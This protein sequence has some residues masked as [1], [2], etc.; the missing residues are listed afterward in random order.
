M[1]VFKFLIYAAVVVAGFD[2]CEVD[3]D[4]SIRLLQEYLRINTTTYSDMQPAVDFWTNLA[5]SVNLPVKV[6]EFYPGMPIVIIKWEGTDD[7]LPRIMLN[8]HMDVVPAD[9]SLWT[10]NP[11][12]G[13]ISEDGKIYGVGSQDMKSVAIQHFEALYRLTQIRK[14]KLRRSIYMTLMSDE[15]VGG[16]FCMQPLVKSDYFKEMNIECEMDEG[17][18]FPIAPI[19]IFYQDKTPWHVQIDCYGEGGHGSTFPLSSVTAVGQCKKVMDYLL[20]YRDEQYDISATAS[21]NNAGVFTSVNLNIMQAGTANNVIPS[22][23]QL[24][25]DIR[26]GSN[27]RED[28][29]EAQ[30]MEWVRLSG[31]KVELTFLLKDPQSPATVLDDSNKYWVA[32]RDAVT[33]KGYQLLPS[34]PPGSTDARHIRSDKISAFGFSPMPNTPLLLHMVDEHVGVT[35][36]LNGIEIFEEIIY[37]LG[38]LN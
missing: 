14:V 4:R 16:F 37:N 15:E 12:E 24:V 35:T 25:F 10:Y 17:G 30:L 3:N 36:F 32:I 20:Q 34:I 7:T 31:P 38:M 22:H 1:G 26:L 11:F 8:S 19:P 23:V 28:D 5:E 9:P 2:A 29:F 13:H 33:R 18:P 6:I 21:I 27:V